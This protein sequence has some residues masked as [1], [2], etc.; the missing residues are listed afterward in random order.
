MCLDQ[1]GGRVSRLAPLLKVQP[2]SPGQLWR[3]ADKSLIRKQGSVTGRLVKLFG[4]NLNLAPVLDMH[5]NEGDEHLK[6]RC[7]GAAPDVVT[8]NAREFIIGMRR[9]GVLACGKHFPGYSLADRDPHHG[10]PQINRSSKELEEFEWIPFRALHRK[11][12]MIMTAHAQNLI[13]DPSGRPAT[14]SPQMVRHV[15]RDKWHYRGCLITDDID[16]GAIRNAY[17]VV[18][19][20]KMAFEAGNDIV[21]VC[22]SID[23]VEKVTETLAALPLAMQE[24]SYARILQAR[25]KLASPPA[26]SHKALRRLDDEVERLHKLTS[27]LA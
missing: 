24:Q 15:L 23:A 26:F 2:A 8:A 22:H 12:D 16:M 11:L 18:D 17:G 13:L 10:L 7:F 27:P 21:L 3:H 25:L 1:E 6:N 9:Q 4:F 20:C 5:V 19:A 14:L